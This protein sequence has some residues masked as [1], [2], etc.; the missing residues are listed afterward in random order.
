MSNC[1]TLSP[2]ETPRIN[3][4]GDFIRLSTIGGCEL[5]FKI[6]DHRLDL[7]EK[8]GPKEVEA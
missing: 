7:S 1:L 6:D 4:K 2:K 8:V 5:N 3:I